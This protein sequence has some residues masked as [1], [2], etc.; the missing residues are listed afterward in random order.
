MQNDNFGVDKQVQI[1][2]RLRYIGYTFEVE[3]VPRKEEKTDV[4]AK[5]EELLLRTK[6]DKYS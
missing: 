3:Y 2:S 6:K 5:M 1:M 4:S